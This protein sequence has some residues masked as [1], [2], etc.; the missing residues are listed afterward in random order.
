MTT[1]LKIALTE[2]EMK[3]LLK[4]SAVDCRRPQEQARYIL[5]S[6]LLNEDLPRNANSDGIRQ[7]SPVAV[8]A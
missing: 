2:N 4:Q 6:V 7:D 1:L 3:L 8:C 5:R